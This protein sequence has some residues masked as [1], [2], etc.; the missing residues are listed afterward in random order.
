V[1]GDG[2]VLGALVLVPPLALLARAAVRRRIGDRS[3]PLERARR[4]ARKTLARSLAPASTAREELE[5]FHAYLAARTRESEQAW[6]GRDFARWCR[7]DERARRLSPEIRERAGALLAR[8]E[9]AV[10]GGTSDGAVEREALVALA[11]ELEGA[12]L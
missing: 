7:T 10:Y 1:P 3:A 6:T 4:R 11:D 9:A 12:G 5:A 8:L 2:F